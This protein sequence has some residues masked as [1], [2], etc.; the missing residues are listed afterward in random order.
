MFPCNNR[1]RAIAFKW[2]VDVH[3]QY[4][5]FGPGGD[6]LSAKI[7]YSFSSER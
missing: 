1:D 6:K 4:I 2:K 3:G 5:V 7:G